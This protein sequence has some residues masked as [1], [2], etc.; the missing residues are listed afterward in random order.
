MVTVGGATRRP[1]WKAARR[2]LAE[3]NGTHIRRSPDRQPNPAAGRRFA[4]SEP[5]RLTKMDPKVGRGPRCTVHK[6]RNLF[7]QAPE[8]LHDEITA[9]YNDII[10]AATREEIAAARPSSAN[11][12]P[13]TA[14][15]PT[16]WRKPATGCSP[17]HDCRRAA[18]R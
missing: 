5:L 18:V 2:R 11:A 15:S 3:V 13:S 17:S 10:Y 14:P 8:R 16:A 6:H 4:T 12:G 7:A 9:D 1:R